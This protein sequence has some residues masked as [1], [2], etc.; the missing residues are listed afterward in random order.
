MQP[1]N[2]FKCAFILP[3]AAQSDAQAIVELGV[4][5]TDVCAIGLHGN[6]VIAVVDRPVVKIYIR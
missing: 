2:R 5:D 4:R 3:N 1:L 6:A